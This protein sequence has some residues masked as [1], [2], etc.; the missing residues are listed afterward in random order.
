MVTVAAGRLGLAAGALPV[1]LGGSLLTAGDPVLTRAIT[2][3]LA[4]GLPGAEV[5]IVEVPPVAGAALLGL[6]QVG[7]PPSA[8]ARLREAFGG[9]RSGA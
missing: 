7:A 4:A 1:V 9:Q 3:R 5:R 6:D 2:S 8:A